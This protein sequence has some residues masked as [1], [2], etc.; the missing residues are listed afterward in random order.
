MPGGAQASAAPLNQWHLVNPWLGIGR[1]TVLAMPN[2]P[3]SLYTLTYGRFTHS[4]DGGATSAITSSPACGESTM[5]VD[6][7][8]PSRVYVGCMYG[9][10]MLQST[11]GGATWAA[12]NAGLTYPGS[13]VLPTISAIAVDPSDGSVYV[14]TQLDELGADVFVSHDG[15]DSWLPIHDGTWANGIAV[16]GGRVYAYDGGTITSD[17]DGATWSSP[18]SADGSGSLVADPDSPGAVYALAAPSGSTG[19]AWVTTDGGG[20][21]T[22]LA[23]HR[24]ISPV[25]RSPAATCIWARTPVSTEVLTRGRRGRRQRPRRTLASF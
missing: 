6:P 7:S 18:A 13:S 22:Q 11:D 10:G 21:W 19:Q 8:D 24:R 17:D 1:L 5:A 15:G 9:G 2:H 25:P 4:T 12:D 23:R 20:Q 3:N 14:T 16:S